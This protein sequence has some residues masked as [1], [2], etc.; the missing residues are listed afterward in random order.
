MSE[1]RKH[2]RIDMEIEIR[3]N[4]LER[5]QEVTTTCNYSDGGALINN[6]FQEPL[7]AGTRLTLQ[8]TRLVMGNEAPVLPVQVVRASE[9]QI[10]CMFIFEETE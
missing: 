10:A 6:P 3:V 9:G 7:P 4:W 5:G 1:Q 2:E 8:A